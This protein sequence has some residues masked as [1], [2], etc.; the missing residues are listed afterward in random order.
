MN[1]VTGES[2]VTWLALFASTGTLIC[3]ALPIALVALGMGATVAALST[4]LPIL[5]SL[6]QHKAWVFLGSALSLVV[7]GWLLFHS[8][9]ECP[10]DPELRASCERILKWNRRVFWTAITIWSVGFLAA[11]AALPLRIWVEGR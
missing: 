3:C 8:G 7:T 1:M 2:R 4:S 5:V 11:Y 9:R 6:T 10:A